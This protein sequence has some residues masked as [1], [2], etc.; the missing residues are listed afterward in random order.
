[1]SRMEMAPVQSLTPIK[2]CLQEYSKL[3]NSGFDCGVLAESLQKL[4]QAVEAV[5]NNPL[6]FNDYTL[7]EMDSSWRMQRLTDDVKFGLDPNPNVFFSPH[8]LARVA[9]QLGDL[10]YKNSEVLPLWFDKID[11]MLQQRGLDAHIEGAHVPFEQAM[12]GGLKN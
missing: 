7:S 3:A 12:F 10:G 9:R 8:N 2:D 6:T 5:G 11:V 1:M 4:N